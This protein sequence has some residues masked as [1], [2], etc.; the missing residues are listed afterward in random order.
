MRGYVAPQP[1][2]E[3][4]KGGVEIVGISPRLI[5]PLGRSECQLGCRVWRLTQLLDVGELTH[6]DCV[7]RRQVAHVIEQGLPAIV[8]QHGGFLNRGMDHAGLAVFG[9][10]PIHHKGFGCIHPAMNLRHLDVVLL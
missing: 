2:L 6:W 3:K 9:L 5:H 10:D 4:F 8:C 7:Q 1:G